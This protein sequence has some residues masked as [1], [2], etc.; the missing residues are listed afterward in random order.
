MLNRQRV[1][2]HLLQQ[3]GRPVSKI[4][5]MKWCFLLRHEMRSQGGAAFYDFLP[6]HFGPFSFCLY[7][8]IAQLVSNGLVKSSDDRF[9]QACHNPDAT[10]GLST[11]VKLDVVRVLRRFS[12]KST[13]YLVNYVYEQYPWFT[14]NSREKATRHPPHCSGGCVHGGLRGAAS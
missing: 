12:E 10:D 1:L 3:A 9:W 8:D 7:R 4:D 6:Y 11:A 13:S 5:L 2:V 14:V